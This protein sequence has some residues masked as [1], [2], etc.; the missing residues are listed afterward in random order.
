MAVCDVERLQV[1]IDE[2]IGDAVGV[3]RATVP[4]L[5]AGGDVVVAGAAVGAAQPGSA[6][7]VSLRT[8]HGS[9]AA[10]STVGATHVTRLAARA[11]G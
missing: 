1:V 6:A 9:V 11:R 2:M 5:R 7:A 4:G 3:P 10:R 8:K